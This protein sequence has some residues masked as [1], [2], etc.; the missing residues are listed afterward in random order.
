LPWCSRCKMRRTLA[1]VL[2]ALPTAAG[3]TVALT[4][5]TGR[6]GRIAVQKLSQRGFSTRLLVRHN[7]EG[8]TPSIEADAPPAAIAAY[9]AK[10]PGVTVVKGDVTDTA[11]VVTLLEGCEAC[12]AL[13][14]ARRTRKLQDLLPWV[15]PTTDPQ[16]AKR[17]N[18][19]GVR[20]LLA[21]AKASG[22]CKRIV[23]ITGKGETPWSLFSI[24]INTMGSLA[25]AW[26]YEGECLLRSDRRVDYTI[27]RPGIMVAGMEA[28][29]EGT[30]LGLA[31]N[32]GDLKVSKIPHASIAELA[33][34]CLAYPN[35]ARSTLCAMAVPTEEG[36]SSYAP[37]LAKVKPDT[38][39][40]APTLLAQHLLAVRVGGTALAALATGMASALVVAV[41]NI[42]RA[43][44]RL[45]V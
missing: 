8:V 39:E 32:G 30:A 31:D 20:H 6:L 4:G 12:L 19:D 35:A 11:S 26:N 3:K 40:F 44:M 13:H 41:V 45:F 42:F 24:L 27:I 1:V 38:R 37:L 15:D 21:A 23:R 34:E 7:I 5:A 33:I 16:H 9:L 22:T 29:D 2:L 36:A 18:Y 14:G 25:K 43:L 17:V 28:L 10:L